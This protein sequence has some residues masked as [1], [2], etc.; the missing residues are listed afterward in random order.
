MSNKFSGKY[1]I[2]SILFLEFNGF[3]YHFFIVWL[4]LEIFLKYLL[5]TLLVSY[6][7]VFALDFKINLLFQYLMK[8]TYYSKKV[9]SRYLRSLYEKFYEN[10]FLK[11]KILLNNRKYQ[12]NFNTL[13]TQYMSTGGMFD[14]T[15]FDNLNR[16]KGVWQHKKL[17]C[18]TRIKFDVKQQLL[19]KILFKLNS[20]PKLCLINYYFD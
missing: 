1:S 20:W 11:T 8:M 19:N 10:F 14:W 3:N 16:T 7:F 9:Y 2:W 17:G 13:F 6:S 15:L 18:L 5:L 4:F 12:T